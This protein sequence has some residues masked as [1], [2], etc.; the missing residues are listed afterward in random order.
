MGP[1]RSKLRTFSF[2][3][4]RPRPVPSPFHPPS[5]PGPAVRSSSS[6]HTL[7]TPRGCSK[8]SA[9]LWRQGRRLRHVQ[10]LNPYGTVSTLRTGYMHALSS[11]RLDMARSRPPRRLT[12]GNLKPVPSYREGNL[13]NLPDW[14]ASLARVTLAVR[15]PGG[16][17]VSSTRAALA[18]NMLADTKGN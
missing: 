16:R 7:F 2:D 8:C 18:R 15:E 3:N 14:I 10:Y 17:A 13:P 4:L 9:M 11:S 5:L 6:P 1:G 12:C